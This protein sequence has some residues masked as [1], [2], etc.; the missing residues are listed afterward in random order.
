MIVQVSD[1]RI[2]VGTA[3]KWQLVLMPIIAESLRA[4]LPYGD[5]FNI[6]LAKFGVSVAGLLQLPAA[7]RSGKTAQPGNLIN[8]FPRL[9]HHEA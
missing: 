2:L 1:F 5:Y 7:E 8:G 4:V 3:D 9:S 6:T